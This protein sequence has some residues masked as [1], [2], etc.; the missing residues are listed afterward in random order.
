MNVNDCYQLGYIVKVHGTKGGV[1]I[2][3]DTDQPELYYEMESV[4]ILKND[5]LI[6]FFIEGFEPTNQTNKLITY[7]EDIRTVEQAHTLKGTKM[8][9]PLADLPTLNEEQ[10]YYHEIKGF[11]I[12]DSLLGEI[13]VVKTI[14][15]M[16]THDMIVFDFEG[17]EIM[18]PIQNPIY[19][20][21]DKGLNTIYVHLPDGYLDVFSSD[22]NQK[23]EDHEV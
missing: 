5:E 1:V 23:E 22:P 14:Y 21:I 4:F 18:I 19:K 10:F 15:E 3:L 11:K 2:Y 16:P 7:F 17:N 6:P 8:F 20:G 13:G 12:I 9:L